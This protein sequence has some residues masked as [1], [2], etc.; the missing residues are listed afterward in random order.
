VPPGSYTVVA[1]NEAAPSESRRVVIPESG[2]DVEANF[3]LG[4]R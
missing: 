4:R 3:A 1:W 2:G